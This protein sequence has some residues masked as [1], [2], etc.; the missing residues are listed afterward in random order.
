M[1]VCLFSWKC[2]I[3]HSVLVS[4]SC[5]DKKSVALTISK[6]LAWKSYSIWFQVSFLSYFNTEFLISDKNQLRLLNMYSILCWGSFTDT[7]FLFAPFIFFLLFFLFVFMAFQRCLVDDHWI[8]L[9]E[10]IQCYPWVFLEENKIEPLLI[11]DD[12]KHKCH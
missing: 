8:S 11:C 5:F 4:A 10:N 6:Y 2:L 1:L 9:I 12:I 3:L 7:Y